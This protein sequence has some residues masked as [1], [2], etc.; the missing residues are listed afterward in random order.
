MLEIKSKKFLCV[1][2]IYLFIYCYKISAISGRENVYD[3]YKYL[4]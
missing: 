2:F 1:K 3:D 4:I